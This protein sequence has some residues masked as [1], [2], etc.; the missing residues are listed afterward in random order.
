MKS[1]GIKQQV[2]N[3]LIQASL[4]RQGAVKMGIRVSSQEIQQIIKDMAPFQEAGSFN[5]ER[6]K[7]VLAANRMA[8]TKFEE[9][10]KYDR[11]A[12]VAARE[13]RNFAGVVTDFEIEELYSRQN[14][15][16]AVKYVKI[17]SDQFV[18]KVVVDD[19]ALKAWYETVKQNYQTEPQ[20]KLNYLVFT[21]AGVA[22]KIAIDPGKI[23]EYYQNNGKVP[24]FPSNDTPGRFFS[25]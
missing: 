17:S 3:Q 18:D 10:M 1:L 14:E 9:S 7:S 21:Y 23:A 25:R 2:I 4:L 8:P 12:E 6:Y 5:I 19:T 22:D 20:I 13:I 11:L 15:K 24:R 16:I